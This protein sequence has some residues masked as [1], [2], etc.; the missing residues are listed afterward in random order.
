[1]LRIPLP[2]SDRR[3]GG[4]D[5]DRGESVDILPLDG[6]R[7]CEPFKARGGMDAL[8][9]PSTGHGGCRPLLQPGALRV[10]QGRNRMIATRRDASP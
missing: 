10:F 5:D 1:M 7:S 9:R 8:P 4:S 3:R 6:A 2:S